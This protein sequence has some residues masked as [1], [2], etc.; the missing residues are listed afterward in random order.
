MER[1]LAVLAD[2]VLALSP[3]KRAQLLDKVVASLDA[4]GAQGTDAEWEA[5]AARREAEIESGS[6]AEQPLET[7]LERLRAEV[8]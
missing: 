5:L 7:V 1:S 6:V 2:E 8:E 3:T 4:P